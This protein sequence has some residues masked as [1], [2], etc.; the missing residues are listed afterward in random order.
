MKISIFLRVIICGLLLLAI[1]L[2]GE[3]RA[4]TPQTVKIGVLATLPDRD[5]RLARTPLPRCEL[6]QRTFKI[7]ILNIIRSDTDSSFATRSM[8]HRVRSML[9]Q[10]LHA[11]GVK[12]VIGPQTSSK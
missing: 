7:S 5:S 6:L 8:M 11:R 9:I 4:T 12:I 2:A 10:D 1:T 3:V